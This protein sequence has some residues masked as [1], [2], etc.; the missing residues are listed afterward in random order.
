METRAAKRRRLNN[1]TRNA[2]P[3]E[4]IEHIL[5]HWGNSTQLCLLNKHMY[6]E[7]KYKAIFKKCMYYLMSQAIKV[8]TNA[9]CKF[10]GVFVGSVTGCKTR[11]YIR[12]HNHIVGKFTHDFYY[13]RKD[14]DGNMRCLLISVCGSSPV[15]AIFEHS[16]VMTPFARN[17]DHTYSM[18]TDKKMIRSTRT[19][20]WIMSPSAIV[21]GIDE[22]E[23]TMNGIRINVWIFRFGICPRSKLMRDIDKQIIYP[24]ASFSS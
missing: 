9:M 2:L 8:K 11:M 13:D 7:H 18:I 19:V 23:V 24:P 21:P 1:Y 4:I 20:S 10:N 12:R 3:W 22:H 6:E 16:I 17:F 5:F 14:N 15:D